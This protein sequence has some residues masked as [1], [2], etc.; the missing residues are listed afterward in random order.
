MA[1]TKKLGFAA[2]A[3]FGVVAFSSLALCAEEAGHEEQPSP[4]RQSWS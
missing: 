2:A 3:L 1:L 4:A